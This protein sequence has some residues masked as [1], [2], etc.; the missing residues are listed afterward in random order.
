LAVVPLKEGRSITFCALSEIAN[1]NI[2][3]VIKDLLMVICFWFLEII[4]P[5]I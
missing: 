5:V 4:S 3:E 2:T 1:R